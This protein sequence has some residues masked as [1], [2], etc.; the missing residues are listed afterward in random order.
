MKRFSAARSTVVGHAL[1]YRGGKLWYPPCG[2]SVGRGIPNSRSWIA[3][4]TQKSQFRAETLPCSQPGF[5][6]SAAPALP[7]PSK[8]LPFPTRE[9]RVCFPAFAAA[10]RERLKNTQNSK[11]KARFCQE[12]RCPLINSSS[13]GF[14]G[15]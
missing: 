2:S 8:H 9:G 6:G 7:L 11:R 13:Q 5:S 12:N 14:Y 1:F 10:F 3:D 15:E 4:K